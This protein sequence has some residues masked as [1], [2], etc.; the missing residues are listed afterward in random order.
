M[1]SDLDNLL[2]CHKDLFC[3]LSALNNIFPT[4]SSPKDFTLKPKQVLCLDHLRNGGNVIAILPTGYGKSL[5]FHLLPF[6]LQEK[7]SCRNIVIV[8]SP[9]S[10]IINDQIKDLKKCGILADYLRI[11]ESNEPEFVSLF[12]Q[13]I[14]E[15]HELPETLPQNILE[16]NL[17]LLYGHP[18]S[19]LSDQGI[20]LVSSKLY[21][22]NVSALVVDEA[23]CI[24]MW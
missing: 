14:L 9:L 6:I 3:L 1:E 17:S 4:Y 21:Q 16:G 23:H 8:V 15:E 18:E 11:K 12:D 24:E 5:I 7:T 19:F 20:K 2:K 22:E 13:L 10:S